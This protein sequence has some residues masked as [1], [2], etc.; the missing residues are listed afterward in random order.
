MHPARFLV[1]GVLFSL[2][3]VSL[4]AFYFI[5]PFSMGQYFKLVNLDKREVVCPWCIGGGAKL[6]EWAASTQG[7]VLTLLLRK[8]DE[9]GGGDYYGYHKGIGEGGAIDCPL[10]PIA[11]RWAGDRIALVGDY[12]SSK[13]WQQLPDFRNISRQL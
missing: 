1:G 10:S 13:L 6:W 8:S 2:R 4:S 3:T 12:D 9:G 11:G 7:A 5:L